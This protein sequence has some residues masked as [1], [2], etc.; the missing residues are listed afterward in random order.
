MELPNIPHR[1]RDAERGVLYVV[2]SYRALSRAEVVQQ[3]R[4]HN[5]SV[6]RRPKKGSTIT[7]LTVLGATE[8]L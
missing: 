6:R 7:I 4:L 8:R 5:G 2:M 1:I 3:I